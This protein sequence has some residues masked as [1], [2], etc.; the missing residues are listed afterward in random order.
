MRWRRDRGGWELVVSGTGRAAPARK[1]YGPADEDRARAEE[2][3][4]AVEQQAAVGAGF[5][6]GSSAAPIPTDEALRGWLVRYRRTLSHSYEQTAGGLIE[7]HLAPH[8]GSRDLRTLRE[9]DALALAEAILAKTVTRKVD[10]EKMAVPLSVSVVRNCLTIMRLV[11]QLHVPDYL[12]RNHFAGVG[13]IVSKMERRGSSRVRRV[14]AWTLSELTKII[15]LAE[16]HEPAL[17]GP[18]LLAAYTGCRRG[19]ALGLEWPSVDFARREVLYCVALVR[20]RAVT[21]KS[22]KERTVPLDRAGSR[23]LEHLED[24]AATLR[25]RT[26]W[27]GD[28]P[29]VV[30]L[31]PGGGQ[32]DERNFQRA[33]DRLRGRF[34]AEGV[35]PL[36]FHA[37]RHTFATL[38]LHAG[39]TIKQVQLWLGHASPEIT[40]RLYGHAIPEAAPRG[41]LE[42]GGDQR[43]VAV[44]GRPDASIPTPRP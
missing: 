31:A 21:P 7:N 39:A 28:N 4:L 27:K 10:G 32:W 15:D 3:A 24:R 44:T 13:K 29:E 12:D 26:A 19:E 1:W 30:F 41:F 42:A 18:V 40:M 36:V 5:L 8:F 6:A 43:G 16:R 17:F 33:W 37:L 9:A 2:A 35:R 34:P 11:C 14:D 38:A 20:G 22:G 25:R 23:L